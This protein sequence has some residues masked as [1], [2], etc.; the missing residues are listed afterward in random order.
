MAAP[1]YGNGG[2]GYHPEALPDLENRAF[3]D[4]RNVL[5]KHWW[6]VTA[7]FLVTVITVAIW[8]FSG[9]VL[10]QRVPSAGANGS[11]CRVARNP[12]TRN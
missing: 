6:L 4:Y 7:V 5:V 2:N 3:R 8:V 11:F 10:P 1:I 9:W 12:A